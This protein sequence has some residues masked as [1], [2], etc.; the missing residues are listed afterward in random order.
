MFDELP[1]GGVGES[2][3]P[4]LHG[5][6]VQGIDCF[7]KL[8]FQSSVHVDVFASD[9]EGFAVRASDSVELHS[10]LSSCEGWPGARVDG[11]GERGGQ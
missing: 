10:V 7:D 5:A 6:E 3:V 1:G 9:S 2:G 8:L 4:I 11:D